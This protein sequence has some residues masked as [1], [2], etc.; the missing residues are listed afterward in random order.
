[1]TNL[2]ADTVPS[3]RRGVPR[4]IVAAAVEQILLDPKVKWIAILHRDTVNDVD[5]FHILPY[6]EDPTSVTRGKLAA[7]ARLARPRADRAVR[8]GIDIF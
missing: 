1:M 8:V 6:T 2:E 4:S 7:T 3:E 5:R